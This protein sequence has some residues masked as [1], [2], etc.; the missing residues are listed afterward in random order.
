MTIHLGDKIITNKNFIGGEKHKGIIISK[1]ENSI[2]IQFDKPEIVN[3][4]LKK[5]KRILEI[6]PQLHCLNS[7]NST[8]NSYYLDIKEFKDFPYFKCSDEKKQ[9]FINIIRESKYLEQ[10]KIPGRIKTNNNNLYDYKQ[11]IRYKEREIERNKENII[12][13]NKDI[14]L[15]KE[16]EK[17]KIS[18]DDIVFNYNKLIKHK[19]I[20]SL[21][22]N[23]LN[24]QSFFIIKTKDLTYTHKNTSVESFNLGSYIFY[25]STTFDSAIKTINYTKQYM[26]GAYHHPC[27]DAGGY[28]CL[29]PTIIDTLNSLKYQK[30]LV[31]IIFTLIH[32]LEKPNYTEPYLAAKYFQ[33]TQP[34][35]IKPKNIFNYLSAQYWRDN[36]KWDNNLYKEKTNENNN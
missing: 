36:E 24:N 21:S 10:K 33:F 19:K 31:G 12:K 7:N 29:G 25:I 4:I 34:T 20:K 35:T 16:K 17:E 28:M 15:L 1:K 32:F 23:K 11:N 30:D 2:G 14:K 9:D 5:A 26:R 27:I 18:V 3:N 13:I 8:K 22:I 6:Q